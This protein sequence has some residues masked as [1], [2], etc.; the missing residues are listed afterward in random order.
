MGDLARFF[1]TI[2]CVTFL[3]WLNIPKP[4]S[5]RIQKAKRPLTPSHA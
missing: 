1:M 5:D 4:A 2:I 3:H